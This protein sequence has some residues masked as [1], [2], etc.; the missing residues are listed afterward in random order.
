MDETTLEVVDGD[1]F[2]PDSG[3]N[4]T[5]MWTSEHSSVRIDLVL[6]LRLPSASSL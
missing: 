4:V 5:K 3:G 6:H 2:V 1:G